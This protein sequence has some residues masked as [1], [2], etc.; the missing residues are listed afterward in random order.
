M[1]IIVSFL[2]RVLRLGGGWAGVKLGGD[3]IS[4]MFEVARAI[5]EFM[6]EFI[7]KKIILDTPGNFQIIPMEYGHLAHIELL[8]FYDVNRASE[9]KMPL[10]FMQRS[11]ETDIKHGYH[12]A[13]PAG[14]LEKLSPL[15]SN[16][17]TWNKKIREAFSQ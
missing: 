17:Y 16:F 4:H 14:D 5:P 6:D 9:T 3:S 12:S 8:V 11:S 1:F 10:S 15:Y 13:T 7:E 2:Q